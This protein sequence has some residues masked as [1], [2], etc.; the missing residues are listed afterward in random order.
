MAQVVHHRPA[1]VFTVLT[2]VAGLVVVVVAAI[3]VRHPLRAGARRV[4]VHQRCLAALAYDLMR[5]RSAPSVVHIIA[6][7]LVL[8]DSV[9]ELLLLLLLLLLLHQRKV[10]DQHLRVLMG[11]N[12]RRQHNSSAVLLLVV[13]LR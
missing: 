10:L 12:M 11:R 6:N 3:T 4:D 2:D 13:Q 1:G 5:G 7:H 8:V 9:Q